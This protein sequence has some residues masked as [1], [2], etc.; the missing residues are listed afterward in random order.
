MNDT[1]QGS[2]I[3][4]QMRE[5]S[6]CWGKPPNK[7]FL[8]FYRPQD[9]MEGEEKEP[10]SSELWVEKMSLKTS[11]QTHLSKTLGQRPSTEAWDW[12]DLGYEC[13]YIV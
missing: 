13:R 3:L 10:G 2:D 7:R 1:R 8:A 4:A 6:H 5:L 12:W 11:L 9:S